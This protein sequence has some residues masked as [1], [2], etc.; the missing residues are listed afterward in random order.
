MRLLRIIGVRLLIA[1]PVLF[2]VTLFT[3]GLVALL[4]GDPATALAGGQFATPE[5]IAEVR[6]ELGLNDPLVVQYGRWLAD[7]VHFDFG[8]SLVSGDPVR[9]EL[10]ERMPRTLSIALCAVVVSVIVGLVAGTIAGSR[11]G[12]LADKASIGLATAA[13]SVPSFVIA[14]LLVQIFAINLG[15]LPAVGYVDFGTSAVD[16]FK[17]IILPGLALAALAAGALSRQL[18]SGL[19]DTVSTDYVRTSWAVGSPPSRAI[20]K[21]AL[22]NSSI[23][24]VAV[25]GTQLTFMIGGTVIIESIFAIQGIGTYMFQS[26]LSTDLPA[27]QGVIIWYVLVQLGVYLLV[28]VVLVLLNPRLDIA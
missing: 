2:L 25:F 20:G 13:V 5:T 18:R 3:F 14:I 12:T 23:P 19:I 7:A 17:S 10:I 24:A 1:I 21:H 8:T 26:T 22:R 28:D 27:I 11:P 4:P 9:D 16:W 6:E 15:W